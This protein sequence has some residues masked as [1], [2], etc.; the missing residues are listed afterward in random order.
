MK[1]LDLDRLLASAGIVLCGGTGGVGKTTTAA[2]LAM[3]AARR[4]RRTLV[5]TVDPARRLAGAMGLAGLGDVPAEVAGVPGL[6]AMMLDA[7]RTFDALVAR[8]APSAATRDAILANRYY[9]ALSRSVAGSKEFMA[10]EKVLALVEAGDYELLI[11]DTPPSQHALDFLDAPERLMALLDGSGLGILLR[12]ATAADRLSFGALRRSQDQ[13]LD[14]FEWLTGHRLAG[15]VSAFFAAFGE[16]IGDF[17]ARARRVQ[18]LLRDPASA[19]VVVSVAEPDRLAEAATF[20]DRLRAEDIPI[21]GLLV[22]RVFEVPEALRDERVWRDVSALDPPLA[23]R[24][25]RA[26]DRVTQRAAHTQRVIEGCTPP[27]L[28]VR[29]VPRLGAEIAS[30]DALARLVDVLEGAA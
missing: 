14:W 21:A 11:V 6:S 4:G 16:I 2:A 10:M 8:Y 9:Q 3:L 19:F 29:C 15:D 13:M 30:L 12:A 5:V 18:A 28:P 27:G 26:L 23:E 17:R 24:V 7:S 20:A 22:N 1:S 25:G